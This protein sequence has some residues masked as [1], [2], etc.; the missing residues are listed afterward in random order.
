MNKKGFTLIE[1]LAVII[2]LG[3]VMLIG[4]TSIAGIRNKINKSMFETKLEF[5][6]SA[7]KSWGQD[8]KELL[9]K[10][11]SV[12]ELINNGSLSTDEV[13]EYEDCEDTSKTDE[14]RVVLDYNGD[15][16]NKLQLYT[17]LEYGRVYACI[18]KNDL[19]KTL[20]QE[21]DSWSLYE[22][23]KFYCN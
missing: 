19:N 12:G 17:Y 13:V 4:T 18:S 6:I 11:I 10:T 15:V 16:M 3:V 23:K 2:L 20:L 9:P 7:A 21:D 5:A 22:H 14:C 8:N 1:L